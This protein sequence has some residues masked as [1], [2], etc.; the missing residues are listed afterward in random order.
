MAVPVQ[1][2]AENVLNQTGEDGLSE[3]GFRSASSLPPICGMKRK[4]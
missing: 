4:D 2:M 3:I 1:D